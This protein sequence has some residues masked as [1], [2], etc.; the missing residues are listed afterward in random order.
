MEQCARSGLPTCPQIIDI[1][2]P[3]SSDG[4]GIVSVSFDDRKSLGHSA[5][6]H[7]FIAGT[8]SSPHS[9]LPRLSSPC[10]SAL[11]VYHWLVEHREQLSLPLSTCRLLLSPSLDERR[12]E[13]A[14]RIPQ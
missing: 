4:F 13:P 7:A 12:V 3:L 10:L 5:G 9:I 14:L 2:H 1:L 11:K 8:S 6:I